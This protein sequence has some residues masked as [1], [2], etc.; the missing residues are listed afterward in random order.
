LQDAERLDG[1]LTKSMLEY[2]RGPI[3]DGRVDAVAQ[4][5]IH[6]GIRAPTVHC[7]AVITATILTACVGDEMSFNLDPGIKY[8]LLLK[9][10]DRM[11]YWKHRIPA[12]VEGLLRRW[13]ATPQLLQQ[14]RPAVYDRMYDSEGPG[15]GSALRD[16]HFEALVRSIPLRPNNKALRGFEVPGKIGG[17][18]DAVRLA[19]TTVPMTPARPKVLAIEGSPSEA[20][21]VVQRG[22]GEAAG[23][24]TAAPPVVKHGLGEAAAPAP[25]VNPLAHLLRAHAT[26]EPEVAAASAKPPAAMVM[27]EVQPKGK[28]QRTSKSATQVEDM[29][30][31][32]LAARTGKRKTKRQLA[33]HAAKKEKWEGGGAG[34]EATENAKADEENAGIGE[35]GEEN[36]AKDLKKKKKKKMKKKVESQDALPD[37]PAVNYPKRGEPVQIGEYMVSYV[38]MSGVE[39]WRA[40]HIKNLVKPMKLDWDD[41]GGKVSAWAKILK[42]VRG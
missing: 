18:L 33:V 8:K 38:L 12:P 30:R 22:L 4:V 41:H 28:G 20:A 40:R 32:A 29:M 5:M 31:D 10:K 15:P 23:S 2:L 27:P 9:V 36:P 3:T 34:A 21:P 37:T 19:D 7:S 16:E 24:A 11:T 6:F 35:A 17:V 42:H 14:C 1:F 13:P 26:T 39:S 25:K